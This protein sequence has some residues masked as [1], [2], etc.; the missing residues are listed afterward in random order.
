ML[1][2][3]SVYKFSRFWGNLLSDFRFS[4]LKIFTLQVK[5]LSSN[6]MIVRVFCEYLSQPIYFF[7]FADHFIVPFLGFTLF[8]V[9][10]IRKTL[11]KNNVRSRN[12]GKLYFFQELINLEELLLSLLIRGYAISLLAPF[13]SLLVTS[14]TLTITFSSLLVIFYSLIDTF[15]SLIVTCTVVTR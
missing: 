9:T 13:Y 10:F 11:F 8:Q 7:A 5:V 6:K 14:C 2:F 15:Y 4:V 3:Q 12:I 1:H